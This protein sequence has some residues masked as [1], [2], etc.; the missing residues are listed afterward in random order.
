M[1][2]SG[3]EATPKMIS[4]FTTIFSFFLACY[5]QS[6]PVVD[7]G[8][9]KYKGFQ[10]KTAGINYYRGIPFAVAPT[11]NLRWRAPVPI[12]RN[13]SYNGQTVDASQYGPSCFQGYPSGWSTVSLAQLGIQE[14]SE[15]CL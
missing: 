3:S 15:D 6:A 8:Y 4:F 9:V 1:A 13:G 12:E 5:A 10:N 2:P 14:Q 7:L 11:G